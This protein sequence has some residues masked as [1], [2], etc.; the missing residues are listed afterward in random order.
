MQQMAEQKKV[1]EANKKI[2]DAK[3]EEE[4]KKKM[5]QSSDLYKNA[6]QATLAAAKGA[7]TFS[8]MAGAM[9]SSITPDIK[10]QESTPAKPVKEPSYEDNA[11]KAEAMAAK[12]VAEDP[13]NAL[14]VLEQQEK[15]DN[16]KKLGNVFSTMPAQFNQVAS[17]S[18]KDSVVART[19]ALAKA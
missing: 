4:E 15:D 3:R 9:S 5:K 17:V 1:E 14:K 6:I 12:L 16:A 7:T 18:A 8:D 19:I 13:Q 2:E 11:S 10:T